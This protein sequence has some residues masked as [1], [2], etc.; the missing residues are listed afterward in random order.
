MSA[1][2]GPLNSP[3]HRAQGQPQQSLDLPCKLSKYEERLVPHLQECS[4]W[5]CVRNGESPENR[6]ELVSEILSIRPES[7]QQTRQL[8]EMSPPLTEGRLSTSD[9]A[10][11]RKKLQT[12]FRNNARLL[13]KLV[14]SLE[15]LSKADSNL[16]PYSTATSTIKAMAN[17]PQNSQYCIQIKPLL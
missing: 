2:D 10:S 5:P 13:K 6:R 9:S 15:A 11:S 14:I 17:P 3:K 8:P 7:T 16:F 4:G 1:L 12:L